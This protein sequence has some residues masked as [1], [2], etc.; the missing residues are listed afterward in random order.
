M[1]F[2]EYLIQLNEGGKATE[3]FG[4]HR[5]NRQD[6]LDALQ[7]ISKH[8]QMSPEL[9]R[10]SLL[11]STHI[12]ISGKKKDS[13]DIDLAIKAN[14]KEQDVIMKKMATVIKDKVYWNAASR[15]ASYA[16]PVTSGKVQCDLVFL[17]TDADMAWS[18]FA[19]HSEEGDKSEYSGTVRNLLLVSIAQIRQDKDKDFVIRDEDDNVVA[20]ASRS[21]KLTTGLERLFKC[22]PKRKDGKGRTKSAA[23]I[24]PDDLEIE[25]KELKPG[26]TFCHDRDPI[27]DPEKAV[28]WLFWKGIKPK[29]VMYAEQI[30]KLIKTDHFTDAQ[31]K[32][33]FS[34]CWRHFEK[35]EIKV[36]PEFS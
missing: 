1:K 35:T 7:F 27:N 25:M 6:I 34:N 19:Y 12:T 29:D 23:K 4:T 9:L 10:D 21:Y 11:G 5:A 32:H 8:L 22:C 16:I 15:I 26:T 13:G 28:E 20:R 2:K 36:P 31:Q 18:K 30:I 3:E 14:I 33:I 17:S 24:D